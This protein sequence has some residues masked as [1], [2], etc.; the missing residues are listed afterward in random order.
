MKEETEKESKKSE[1]SGRQQEIERQEEEKLRKQNEKLYSKEKREQHIG[2]RRLVEAE[3]KKGAGW[4]K[5]LP[6]TGSDAHPRLQLIRH[7]GL[8]EAA[9]TACQRSVPE[10]T[11]PVGREVDSVAVAPHRM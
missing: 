6:L 2:G 10:V 1:K 4:R 11:C 5:A 7:C 3:G 9:F 8:P